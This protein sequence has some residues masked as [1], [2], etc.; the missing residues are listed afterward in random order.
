[1]LCPAKAVIVLPSKVN[2]RTRVGSV[3]EPEEAD[4]IL[5]S[6]M[7]PLRR[8]SRCAGP[9]WYVHRAQ[10]PASD[11]SRSGGTSDPAAVR[12][13]C[14][15]EV[16]LVLSSGEG[17]GPHSGTLEHHADHNSGR[18]RGRTFGSPGNTRP[19]VA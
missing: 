5:V 18:S 4:D 11:G 13:D 2:V 6:L 9:R 17:F 3:S 16:R 14:C 1:M 7:T 10:R 12:A 8:A 15:R 19:L